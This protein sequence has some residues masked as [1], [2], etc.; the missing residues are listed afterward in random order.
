MKKILTLYFSHSGNT[1]RVAERIQQAVG[2]DIAE[3][4]TREPYPAD[5]N[6][7]VVQ[8]KRE[9]AESFK[10]PLRDTIENVGDYDLLILGSP[11]WWYTIAPPVMTFLAENDLANKSIAPFVTHAG[12]GASNSFADV[13]K[14]SPKSNVLT[15][16][17]FRDDKASASEISKWLQKIGF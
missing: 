2:G 1:R 3:I 15:G 17:A 16:I 11:V 12:G 13:K 9:L 7:V 6:T 4:K 14:L 5:Y 8:A 10:P